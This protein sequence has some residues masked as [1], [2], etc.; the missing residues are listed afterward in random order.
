MNLSLKLLYIAIFQV[1]L[2]SIVVFFFF[3]SEYRELSSQSLNSVE[4]F[5]IEQKERE[6]KNYTALA[7]SSVEHMFAGEKATGQQAQANVVSLLN[8]L[9]YNGDDGYFFVYSS[10][11]VNIA[12]PKEPF[13]IGKNWWELESDNGEK[14]AQILIKMHKLVAAFI[15]TNGL[16]LLLTKKLIK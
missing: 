1:I 16:N 2:T 7:V 15:V 12:H 10:D 5:L 9:L 6:L 3:S 4:N 11:G 14:I 8:N 13:R